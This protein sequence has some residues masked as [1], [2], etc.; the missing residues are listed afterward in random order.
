M[1]KARAGHRRSQR[2]VQDVLP[3]HECGESGP[4]HRFTQ[5]DTQG[6]TRLVALVQAQEDDAHYHLAGGH[7]QDAT[8]A[9]HFWCTALCVWV[10]GRGSGAAASTRT[11]HT[12]LLVSPPTL[13]RTKSLRGEVFGRVKFRPRRRFAQSLAAMVGW[14]GLLCR[15]LRCVCAW[16]SLAVPHAALCLFAAVV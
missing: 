3:L 5:A 11:G 13:R 12:P 7:E 16:S 9:P 8:A 15:P 2:L 10:R 1:S 14:L 6:S 4:P